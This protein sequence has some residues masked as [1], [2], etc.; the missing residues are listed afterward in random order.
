MSGD[1]PEGEGDLP[2]TGVSWY[3]AAAYAA[4]VGKTLPNVYQ[5]S[6]A[7]GGWASSQIAPLSNFRGQALAPAGGNRGVGPYGTYDMAGNA[8]EWVWNANGD[9]RFILGGAWNEPSYMFSMV[10]ARSPLSR[11]PTFGFRLVK[12]LDHDTASAGSDPIPWFVRDY[13]KERPVKPDVFQAFKREYSYDRGPMNAKVESVDDSSERW[14]KEKISFAAAYGGERVVAY[15]F[16]P[17]H[18]RPPYQVVVFFPPPSAI[19]SRSSENLE[20]M[21][22]VSPVVSS[23]RALLYPVYKST[24]ERGDGLGSSYPTPTAVASYREHVI[25]WYQDLG[26]SIDYGETRT[27]LDPHR[28][29]LLGVCWGAKLT[30][31]LAAIEDR[32]KAGI[33]I[34]G[35]LGPLENAPDVDPFNFARY[36][37]QPM[38]MVNGRYD[39]IYPVDIAQMPLFALLGSPPKD[40]RHVIV[41]ADLRLHG[42]P[43]VERRH[44]QRPLHW[45]PAAGVERR[46]IHRQL[47]EVLEEDR[48]PD[49]I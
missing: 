48:P 16:T 30:P 32:I 36:V 6:R 1:Y 5:W 33:M 24:Y 39:F 13:R 27:D 46:Q 49:A 2:V 28:I 37:R 15:L 20:L 31:L 43:D 22:V 7:A 8:K 10:D 9:K 23:G 38:L 17:R 35:G 40:K 3:E 45:D 44:L 47:Q 18:L 11:E 42:Q 14:H 19:S 29:A 41:E 12:A 4:F 25:E 21:R 34:G 26:R